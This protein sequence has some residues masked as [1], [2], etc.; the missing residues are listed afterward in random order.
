MENYSGRV[1]ISSDYS[2]IN[3]IL[4]PHL[5]QIFNLYKFIK[6]TF[7]LK[8][9]VPFWQELSDIRQHLHKFPELS[10]QEFETTLFIEEKLKSWGLELKRFENIE[11]GGYCDLGNGP[12]IAFRSDI[13][14]LPISEDTKHTVLSQ[15]PGLMHACGHDYHITIG[16][17]LIKYFL[18]NKSQL[19]GT[20]RLI[21]QP[22]EEAAPGGAEKVIKED[23]LEKVKYILTTHVDPTI[24]PWKILLRK[25]AVQASST[26][27]NIKL[28]GR[29]GHTSRPFLTNDLIQI[30]SQYIVQLTAFLNQITDVQETLAFAF[31]SIHGG[32]THNIIPQKV[33]LKGTLRTLDNEILKKTLSDIHQ[34]S[35]DFARLYGIKVNVQF[36]T[37]CPATINGPLLYDKFISFIKKAGLEDSLI[38]SQKPSLGAD[39]F[40]FFAQKIP[41]LYLMTGGKGSGLLHSGDLLLDDNLLQPTIEILA[42]FIS[43]LSKTD[44]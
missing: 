31:G 44:N 37:N 34:F 33:I 25:G 18:E 4:A 21:F 29:G 30:S 24:A 27:L 11:T 5:L 41:G 12:V 43:Y 32:S 15:Y 38:T 39:D 14:A 20:L 35:K 10:W 26:S 40:A 36:P 16:L 19:K 8:T 9:T 1:T 2:C 6:K 7:P 3:L 22:A 28:T 17:G 13:D 23:I 42:G